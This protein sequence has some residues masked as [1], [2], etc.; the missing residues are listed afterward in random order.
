[1]SKSRSRSKSRSQ[2]KKTA[3]APAL[4]KK[5]CSGS[6]NPEFL[7][8]DIS[9]LILGI[10]FL[11]YFHLLVDPAASRQVDDSS[12]CSC[13]AYNLSSPPRGDSL[14]AAISNSSTP[15]RSLLVEFPDVVN[16]STI[17][18]R[19]VHD[20]QHHLETSGCPDKS[21]F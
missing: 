7:L 16:E 4:A 3:P 20:V 9:F 5:G 10:D 1:M 17:L 15:F 6:G 11:K 14:V 19:P 18:P 21:P 13:P 12:L 2:T 8:A